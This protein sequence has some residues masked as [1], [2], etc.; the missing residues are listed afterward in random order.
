MHI[1][2]IINKEPLCPQIFIVVN[3][4]LRRINK[5]ISSHVKVSKFQVSSQRNLKVKTSGVHPNLNLAI[6]KNKQLLSLHQRREHRHVGAGSLLVN[7]LQNS[8]QRGIYAR[9]KIRE[10]VPSAM[11]Y[12]FAILLISCTPESTVLCRL[13]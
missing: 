9:G 13:H 3:L 4:L 5:T 8:S 2:K 11:L 7:L 12:T 1:H 10:N 6:S